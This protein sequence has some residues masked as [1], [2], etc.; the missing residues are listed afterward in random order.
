MGGAIPL[1]NNHSSNKIIVALDVSDLHQAF[2]LIDILSPKIDIFKIGVVPH[3]R[4]GEALL[5]KLGSLNKKVFLD[6][7][8]HDIPNTVM[9]AVKAAA[10]KDIFMVDVHCSGGPKMLEAAVKGISEVNT[11]QPPLLLGITVLTSMQAD[12]L[13]RLGVHETVEEQ[14]IKLAC[15]AKEAGLPGVVASAQEATV[16]KK[17]LGDEFIV[18]TPGIRPLWAQKKSDD[19]KRIVTPSDAVR[20]GADYVVIGRPIIEA[21][22]PLEAAEKIIEELEEIKS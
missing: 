22:N 10:E 13:K 4:F 5:Q 15:M 18:V 17:E 11:K 2:H 8:F 7:K 9:N 21:P 14:V 20:A 3:T 6:L 12:E 16:I 19:Q 1:E